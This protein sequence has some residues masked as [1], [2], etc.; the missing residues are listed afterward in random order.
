MIRGVPNIVI[1]TLS[2]SVTNGAK[3]SLP[4]DSS[5]LVYSHFKHVS[6]IQAPKGTQGVAISKLNLL[7]ALITQ[8]NQVNKNGASI[9][10]GLKNGSVDSIIDN[11]VNQ[12]RQAKAD[13][14]DM[15]YRPSPNAQQGA[16]FNLIT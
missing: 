11:L 10:P 7:D 4:V 2:Y 3:T 1:P 5:S 9:G 8:I 15:P 12:V 13:N 14:A 6:G 16:L